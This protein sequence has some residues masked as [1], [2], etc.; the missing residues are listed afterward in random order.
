M[1]DEKKSFQISAT[2]IALLAI[3]VLLVSLIRV[4][5]GGDRGIMIVWKGEL[6]FHD[7]LVNL[8]EITR[9]PKEELLK[10]HRSVLYQLEAMDLIEQD[11]ELESVRHRLWRGRGS[12]PANPGGDREKI[13]WLQ[14]KQAGLFR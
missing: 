9:T 7:T 12:P 3:L 6:S 2:E 4:Y 11:V 5:Y 13:N 10:H 14:I 1:S 8:A